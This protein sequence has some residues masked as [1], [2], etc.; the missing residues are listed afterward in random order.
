MPKF[1]IEREIPG[2]GKMSAE[3]LRGAAQL[4]NSVIQKLGPDIRWEHSYV[5]GD[6]I[7]CVYEAPNEELIRAHAQESGFPANTITLVAAEIG[8][9]TAA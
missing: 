8:P 5:T 6:K 3:E 2:A 9:A 7:F 4:S 1:V